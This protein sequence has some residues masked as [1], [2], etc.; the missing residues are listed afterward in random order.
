MT[1]IALDFSA[2][3]RAITDADILPDVI[4]DNFGFDG[5]G[6]PEA[7]VTLIDKHG[8]PT[9]VPAS[10]GW[11]FVPAFL[12]AHSPFADHLDMISLGDH[13]GPFLRFGAMHKKL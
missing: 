12:R 8:H 1:T 6:E 3:Y 4:R 5:I 11:D 13:T 2:S 10:N 9:I 7:A